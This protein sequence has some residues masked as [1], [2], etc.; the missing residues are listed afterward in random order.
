MSITINKQQYTERL[1]VFGATVTVSAPYQITLG[2][3][4]L[5]GVNNF[6]LKGLTA[7]A[8]LNLDPYPG[9]PGAIPNPNGLPWKFK[10]GNSESGIW[11]FSGG[12][13]ASDERVIDSSVFGTGQY[14]YPLIQPI[15]FSA[16]ASILYEVEDAAG[17]PV[18]FTYTI[19]M[20][21][22]GS[23]LTPATT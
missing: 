3:L 7:E 8:L 19:F 17:L 10:L 21:F 18:G 20:G 6:L 11:Y 13:G 2:R 23:Y 4:I 22:H 9:E 14:P 16:G 1:Q 15:L 5:P 12:I